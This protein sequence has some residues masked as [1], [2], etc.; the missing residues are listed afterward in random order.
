MELRSDHGKLARPQ[1]RALPSLGELTRPMFS[2]AM[3][4]LVAS[5]PR[6]KP[7]FVDEDDQLRLYFNSFVV[8]S[9]GKQRYVESPCADC[10]FHDAM[11]NGAC[12]GTINS[13]QRTFSG[14]T[15][16]IVPRLIDSSGSS[17]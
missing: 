10:L 15:P 17:M 1:S 9:A 11:R 2:N 4:G 7:H 12:C 3:P 14:S 6:L 13:C 16:H 8:E 5:H